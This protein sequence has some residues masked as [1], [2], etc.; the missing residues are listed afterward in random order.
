M[1]QISSNFLTISVFMLVAREKL[2]I[3]ELFDRKES[4]FVLNTNEDEPQ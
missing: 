3:L 1:C 4:L 2:M